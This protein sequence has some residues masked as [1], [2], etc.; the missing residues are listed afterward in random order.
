MNLNYPNYEVI[1]VDNA[2]SDE[3]PK[4]VSSEFPKA[5]QIINKTNLGFAG[6]VNVG[7]R[8]AKGEIIALVNNDVVLDRNWLHILVESMV[9]FPKI[10]IIGGPVLFYD[11]KSIIWSAGNRIDLVTG[12]GW[13]VGRRKSI[14]QSAVDMSDVDYVN[15]C[16]VLIR[17]E[18]FDRIGLLDENYFVGWEDADFNVSAARAG[19][20]CGI[21]PSSLAWH[22]ISYSRRKAPVKSY[23]HTAKGFFRFCLKCFP[24]QYVLTVMFCQLFLIPGFELLVFKKSPVYLVQ[25]F[26]AFFSN[27]GQLSVIIAERNRLKR[28]G[29]LVLKNR[30]GEVLAIA[31]RE[32]DCGRVPLM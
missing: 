29:K 17:K 1:V 5:K 7:I 4:I 26:K 27:L 25:R 21:V 20:D 3:S 31:L 30:L 9:R 6:G 32:Q 15:F 11:E 12:L 14:N 23:Y 13:S 24:L 22:K 2:S 16:A 10:G 19:Y 8:Q 28:I 18:V